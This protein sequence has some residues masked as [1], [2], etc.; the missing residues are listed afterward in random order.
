MV[1]YIDVLLALNLFINFLLLLGTARL[2]RLPR[3]RGRTVLGA[4]VGALACL[5]V[6]WQTAPTL[7]LAVLR[8]G[9]AFLM[10]RTAF[11]FHGWKPYLRQ[12]VVLFVLSTVFAG[13]S[14]ALYYF[15]APN[16]FYVVGGVVYYNVSPLLLIAL[17]AASYVVILLYDRVTRSRIASGISYTIAVTHQ[18]RSGIFPAI[19]DTGNRLTEPFS[20]APVAVLPYP[21]AQSLLPPALDA[22]V[23]N[24]LE[25]NSATSCI[26][27]AAAGLRMIP[28]TSIGGKGALPAFRPQRISIMATPRGEPPQKRKPYDITG[29]Y[30]AIETVAATGDKAIVGSALTESV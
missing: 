4:T 13:V 28:Y 8:I 26:T 22:A 16:G 10:I 30:I 5:T 14:F 17:S 20:G 3:H 2:L 11:R 18:G 24:L 6:L 15:V 27:E 23:C 29:A 1:L 7:L 25:E 9:T 12:T 21:L 19:H